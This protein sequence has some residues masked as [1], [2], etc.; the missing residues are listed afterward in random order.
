[1]DTG[2]GE[3]LG[4]GGAEGG[5]PQRRVLLG[6]AGARIV[7]FVGRGRLAEEAKPVVEDD[8]LETLRADIDTDD[9]DG[10]SP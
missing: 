10:P 7:R 6:P 5:I 4:D 1:L 2:A 9:G 3:R 8:G